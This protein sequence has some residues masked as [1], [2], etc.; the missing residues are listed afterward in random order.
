MGKFPEISACSKAA[1]I[2]FYVVE[3]EKSRANLLRD[4]LLA[5]SACVLAPRVQFTYSVVD[6]PLAWKNLVTLL[7]SVYCYESTRTLAGL[8]PWAKFSS[9]RR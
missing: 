1:C 8:A 4:A 3:G 5:S 7:Y 9:R 6:T 2:L